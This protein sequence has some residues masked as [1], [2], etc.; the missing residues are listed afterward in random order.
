M[1]RWVDGWGVEVGGVGGVGVLGI[2]GDEKEKEE[3]DGGMRSG[4][5]VAPGDLSPAAAVVVL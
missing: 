1:R 5:L 2:L 3:E 4:S